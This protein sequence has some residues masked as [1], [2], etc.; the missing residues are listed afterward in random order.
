[1][2]AISSVV[3]SD[4]AWR[5]K[6]SVFIFCFLSAKRKFLP[7]EQMFANDYYL[8][9]SIY[10]LLHFLLRG[11]HRVCNKMCRG[12]LVFSVQQKTEHNMSRKILCLCPALPSSCSPSHQI[13]E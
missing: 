5:I 13:S 7:R 4:F 6:Y 12:V 9:P 8:P 10:L 2:S 11:K 1:M 3:L